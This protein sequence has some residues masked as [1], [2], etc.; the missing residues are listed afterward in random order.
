MNIRLDQCTSSEVKQYLQD[1]N[2][3]WGLI[4]PVGCT[5]QH[6]P[7]LPLGCDTAIARKA[8]ES[9]SLNLHKNTR[10]KALVL[11]DFSY[12]P[13]PGAEWTAGTVSVNFDF[14]GNGLSEILK[15]A[16]RS[17]WNFITI[18]NG[19]G[20]NHGR[21]IEA[22]MA[23]ANGAYGKKIPVVVINIYDFFDN[24]DHI[25]LNCGTHAGEFEIA[26]YHYYCKEYKFKEFKIKR[27][28]LNI[29]PPNIFGLDIKKRSFNGIIS[30]DLPAL[31]KALEKSDEVG[32]L[33]DESIKKT[34]IENLDIYFKNW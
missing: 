19:H 24:I 11:P 9:L 33:I 2:N 27:T 31:R 12:T 17:P 18:I 32:T 28:N 30:K 25:G 21:C 22:S 16:L 7:Y 14:L 5:E 8:A 3:K 13:S 34:L 20:H 23:G 6:G 15:G 29:R 26:L 10:Y 4:L 1:P